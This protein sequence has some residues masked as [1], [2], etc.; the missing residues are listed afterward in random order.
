MSGHSPPNQPQNMVTQPQNTQPQ[1]FS[2]QPQNRKIF[3]ACRSLFCPRV[4]QLLRHAPG[5]EKFYYAR[6]NYYF[7]TLLGVVT[8][9]KFYY[10]CG[11]KRVAVVSGKKYLSR[12]KLIPTMQQKA[13]MKISTQ[14][15][16]FKNT[17][18]HR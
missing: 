9:R 13:R 2:G 14:S 6:W 5:C 7:I 4:D 3:C 15:Y 10:T 18:R 1:N 11:S 12:Q 17:F 8:S 16:F